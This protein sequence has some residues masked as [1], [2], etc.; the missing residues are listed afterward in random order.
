MR[1]PQLI[2]D[3]IREPLTPWYVIV[4]AIKEE[5]PEMSKAFVV[6]GEMGEYS[7]KIDWTVA[8]Y[9]DKERADR[10]CETL[11]K[12]AVDHAKIVD[13]E[14][15]ESHPNP[16]DPGVNEYLRWGSDVRYC[17]EEIELRI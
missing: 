3:L 14:E 10:F 2:V 9:L 12:W 8:V 15:R 17:V 7:D 5:A 1:L 6:R 16:L 4:D 11:Q 13:Y